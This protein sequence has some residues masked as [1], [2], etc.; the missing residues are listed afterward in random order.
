MTHIDYM[1]FFVSIYVFRCNSVIFWEK[2][3]VEAFFF[4][5]KFLAISEN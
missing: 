1:S 3:K 4:S 5:E 2:Y